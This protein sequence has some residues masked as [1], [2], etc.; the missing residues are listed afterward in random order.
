MK[1][2]HKSLLF[3]LPVALMCAGLDAFSQTIEASRK[4]ILIIADNDG[5][6][7]FDMMAPF[8]AFSATGQANVYLVAEHKSRITIN[9]GLY[10][11][12]HFT[13]KEIDSLKITAD[14]LVVP[15][16]SRGFHN[17]KK[18]TVNF[19]KQHY[20]GTNKIL[21]VCDGSATVAAT[22][23]YDGKDLTTHSSDY[24][25]LKKH[26]KR[27]NWV[28]GTTVT[29][30]S[31][32][33][34]TA[35]VANATEGALTVINELFG[36]QVMETVM[37][38]INYPSTEIRKAHKN[39]L[40]AGNPIYKDIRK[41]KIKH[42]EKVGVLL[43]DGISEF[44]LA[45]ILDCY[46]RSF[47]SSLATYTTGAKNVTSKFGL[48]LLPTGDLN[49]SPPS[50]IH[51]LKSDKLSQADRALVNNAAIVSYDQHDKRY[52]IDTCL[53]RIGDLYSDEYMTLVKL[54]LDYNY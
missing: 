24:E 43:Q 34:S 5:T 49:L 20:T 9:R 35:G 46:Y 2:K 30:T 14:V 33:F 48:I 7:I 11:L 12:P 4:N 23:L 39:R 16:Q 29:Q 27:P 8:Y 15:N 45:A 1:T 17:Q 40:V 38:E 28:L 19:I 36:H 31:N 32:L 18:A 26:Y 22:G 37:S 41:G 6:E 44:D 53:R 21:S 25:G 42:T 47:P 13:F 10:A 3:F 52:I 50:E 54:M 51:V